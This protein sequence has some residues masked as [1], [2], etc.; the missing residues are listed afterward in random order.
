MAHYKWQAIT[1]IIDDLVY[2]RSY[3]SQKKYH[4]VYL[5]PGGSFRDDM[6]C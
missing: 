6:A 3:K 5:V 2:V 4:L 1:W